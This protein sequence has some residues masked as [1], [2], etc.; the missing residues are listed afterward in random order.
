VDRVAAHGARGVVRGVLRTAAYLELD[1]FVMALT[2]GGVPLTPNGVAVTDSADSVVWPA[3]GVPVRLAP[4][5]LHVGECF[6]TWSTERPPAWDPTVRAPSADAAQLRRRAQAI[7]RARGI[8]PAADPATLAP[9]FSAGG[10]A[11][12]A[13]V[14]GAAG[15]ALLLRSVATRDPDSAARAGDLLIGRGSGLTPEGDDLWPAR[16][17]S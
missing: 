13:G 6:V 15:V 5:R 8:E 10:L 1:G 11:T 7:L 2:A 3:I 14:A 4:G 9:R 17:W 16:P 12:V